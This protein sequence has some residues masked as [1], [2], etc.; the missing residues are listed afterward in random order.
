MACAG[1]AFCLVCA[2]PKLCVLMN[3]QDQ[4]A[5]CILTTTIEIWTQP[6]IFKYKPCFLVMH[7]VLDFL[8]LQC[9]EQTSFCLLLNGLILYQFEHHID[10][11]K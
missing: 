7:F 10:S 4:A 5:S 6:G 9:L 8:S 1:E 3:P 2:G 11:Y